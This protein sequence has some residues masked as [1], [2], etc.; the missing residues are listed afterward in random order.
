MINGK[1]PPLQPLHCHGENT[2]FECHIEKCKLIKCLK[3]WMSQDAMPSEVTCLANL[4]Y[5][6]NVTVYI[7]SNPDTVVI[8]V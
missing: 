8:S 6:L 5:Y 1:A 3:V 2:K 4:Q 7:I